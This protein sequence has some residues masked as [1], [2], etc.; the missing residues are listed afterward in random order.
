MKN[1]LTTIIT[2][3]SSCLATL[4]FLAIYNPSVLLVEGNSTKDE[5]V[6]T[7]NLAPLHVEGDPCFIEKIENGE[8]LGMTSQPFLGTIAA[9]GFNFPPR[10]WAQCN[11]QLL[12]ISSNEALFSLLGT[13]YGGDG[14]TTFGLPDLR[15][16]MPIHQG[17][18]PGLSNRRIGEKGGAE[19]TTRSTV[20]TAGPGRTGNVNVAQGVNTGELNNMPPYQTVNWC[21][22]TI[23]IFPSRD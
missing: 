13:I 23:G 21:I 2:A 17:Q 3:V 16:R 20:S 6:S 1:H 10:G 8:L 12:P 11:G 7:R 15:G 4:S 19:T 9:F 22:A 5:I 14:R 18:G